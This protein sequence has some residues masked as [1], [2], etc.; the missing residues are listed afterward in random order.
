MDFL[1]EDQASAERIMQLAKR[2]TV[3]KGDL[4]HRGANGILMRCITQEEGCELLAEIR[5]GE[6]E[7][8]PSRYPA[9]RLEKPSGV[10]FTGQLRLQD[11]AELV[12]PA[13]HARLMQANTH[14]GSDPANG[15]TRSAIGCM[16]GI[17]RLRSH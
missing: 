2:Y 4:Y 11:A 7:S 1:P 15:S 9:H 10:A 16:G 13:K 12:S 14:T 6:C 3:V 17:S 5:G 8:H